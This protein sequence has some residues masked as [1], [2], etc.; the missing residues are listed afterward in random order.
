MA[1]RRP[2]VLVVDDEPDMLRLV[3][4]LVERGVPDCHVLTARDGAEGYQ[5]VRRNEI[6]LAIVDY[7]MPG[8]DGLELARR[9]R[10]AYQGVPCILM[11][12]YAD[13]ALGEDALKEGLVDCVFKKPL[14]PEAFLGKVRQ[15]LDEPDA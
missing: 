8:F 1:A 15:L 10:V 5:V 14:D 4:R 7:R 3:A 11:T 13:S 6:D 12:A 9:L 2:T